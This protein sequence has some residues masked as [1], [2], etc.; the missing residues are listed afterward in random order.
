MLRQYRAIMRREI[1]YMW[2]DKSLRTILLLGPLLGLFLFAGVYSHQRIENISTAV[3][4]LDR[5]SASQQV[6]TGLKNAQYLQVVT[7]PDH[8]AQLEEMIKRSEVVVGVVIPENYGRD[9]A[10]RQQARVAVLIDGTNMAYA[11]NATSAVL[12]VTRTL[13][14][15]AG[16]KTLIARG[17]TPRQA[18][19]AYQS[20]EFREEAWFN[21]T[22]NYAYFLALALALNIWQQCCTLA[23]CMNII[24]ENGQRSWLQIKA[25]GISV[26]RLFLAKSLVQIGV[27]MLIVMHVYLIAF[28]ALKFPLASG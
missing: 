6:V 20:I 11:T 14:A 18:Q 7:Y 17:I 21:P 25:S 26:F 19:E 10:R 13:G 12:A 1:H 23:S 24:G 8:Y 16:V 2:R 9:I 22:L 28:A 15:E 4:D 5:S 3:L 27:M